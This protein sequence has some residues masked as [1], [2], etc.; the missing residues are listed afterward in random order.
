MTKIEILEVII[1][2]MERSL[3]FPVHVREIIVKAQNQK[4][5]AGNSKVHETL[6]TNIEEEKDTTMECRMSSFMFG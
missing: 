3:I 4:N 2:A 1:L 6:D 5:M